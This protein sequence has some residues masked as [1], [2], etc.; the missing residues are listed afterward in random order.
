MRNDQKSGTRLVFFV[1]NEVDQVIVETF[2]KQLLAPATTVFTVTVGGK[3]AA[4]QATYIGI[5]ELLPKGYQHFF[6]LFD[7]ET[8]S[9]TKIAYYQNLIADPIKQ[10]GLLEYVTFCPIVPNINAWLLGKYLL[11]AKIFGQPFNLAKIAKVAKTIDLD[12]LRQE[13]ASFKQ[14]AEALQS[15]V[16]VR[17]RNLKEAV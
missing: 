8:T 15:L 4:F 3:I 5:L 2:A 6:I 10:E 1:E 12:V 9:A 17:K 11:P 14:F 13:N 7:T 16:M